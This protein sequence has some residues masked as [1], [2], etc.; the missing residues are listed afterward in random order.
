MKRPLVPVVEFWDEG[1]KIRLE[2]L[3][4]DYLPHRQV[5]IRKCN[6]ALYL[7]FI[8]NEDG[9]PVKKREGVYIIEIPKAEFPIIN[10]PKKRYKATWLAPNILQVV[11]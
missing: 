11:F 3:N 8:D 10:P 2:L 5:I 7:I 1:E 6:P 9:Y 4:L